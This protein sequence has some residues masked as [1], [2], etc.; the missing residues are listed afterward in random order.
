M[1]FNFYRFTL[2]FTVFIITFTQWNLILN[3][4]LFNCI[5]NKY[6]VEIPGVFVF[7]E[8]SDNFYIEFTYIRK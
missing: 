1:P 8:L 6:H 7:V 3:L 5:I 4:D 2:K